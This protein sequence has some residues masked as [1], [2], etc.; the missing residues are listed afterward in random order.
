VLYVIGPLN[1]NPGDD[2]EKTVNDLRVKHRTY[3]IKFDVDHVGLLNWFKFCF[4]VII[5]VVYLI[6]TF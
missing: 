4:Y 6:L 2:L 3:I 5:S 1:P